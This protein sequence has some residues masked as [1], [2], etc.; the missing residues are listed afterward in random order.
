MVGVIGT[1]ARFTFDELWDELRERFRVG[2]DVPPVSTDLPGRFLGPVLG[3]RREF[4][5]DAGVEGAVRC[6]GCN[7]ERVIVSSKTEVL[8]L[9]H[10]FAAQH[11]HGWPR[12][13]FL[14]L[15]VWQ[16]GLSPR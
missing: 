7:V 11:E 6:F 16:K 10:T 3:A 1:N 13:Q 2:D 15:A 14:G 5:D 9:Q 8:R 12:D 4:S